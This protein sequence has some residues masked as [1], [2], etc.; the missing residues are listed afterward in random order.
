MH[1]RIATLFTSCLMASMLAA[2]ASGK[3]LAD[4]CA[5][6]PSGCQ[7]LACNKGLIQEVEE[8]H[9]R[10][11]LVELLRHTEK[12]DRKEDQN[13][14]DE[15]IRLTHK[16]IEQAEAI[17]EGLIRAG[18][19]PSSVQVSSY[20]RTRDTAARAVPR[21]EN[22]TWGEPPELRKDRCFDEMPELLQAESRTRGNSL[23]VT[24]SS[25][26]FS[27]LYVNRYQYFDPTGEENYGVMIFLDRKNLHKPIAC[28]WPSDWKLWPKK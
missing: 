25:C 9:A 11:D 15:S 23:Y 14:D 10:G 20:K 24:H 6:P 12:E 27:M 18:L 4:R 19:I 13:Q 28:M 16:G 21:R 22:Q 2:G 26:I 1:S 17:H 8:A 5:Q 7:V 3:T